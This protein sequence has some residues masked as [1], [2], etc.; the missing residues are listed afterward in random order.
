MSLIKQMSDELAIDE[1]Y[2]EEIVSNNDK[3]KKFVIFGKSGEPRVIFQPSKELKTLQYWIINRVFNT[4]PVSQYSSA[5]EKN[6][7]IKENANV[8][9]DS[10]F[11]LHTD[12]RHFF[13]NINGNHIDELVMQ[14]SDKLNKEDVKLIKDIVL[15]KNQLVIG[16]VSSPHISNCIMYKFDNE[17]YDKIAELYNIKKY[18]RY[19]DD[20]VISSDNFI[21]SNI[22]T[23]IEEEL[24][25]YGFERN[26]KK[27][28]FMNK[29]NRRIVTGIVID[30]NTN[31]LSLGHKQYREIKKLLY[32]KL[33]K[34]RG[35]NT[36][37]I[38]YLSYLRNIDVETY[39]RLKKIYAK[40]GD[41]SFLF[42][43]R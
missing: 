42:L 17:F 40:Y 14:S 30:N 25:K 16:S 8:H 31:K 36:K 27:T 35:D 43:S 38:G 5:Y 7:S 39:L 24:H 10:S 37:I 33:V 21:S 4:Y 1:N 34:G 12:I 20:I 29:K 3:Y 32:N 9:K 19:A 6:C 13:A 26:I 28:Y 18:T 41:I 15:F 22:I 2:I 23:V 11:I